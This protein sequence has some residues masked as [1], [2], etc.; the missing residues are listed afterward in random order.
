MLRPG[1]RLYAEEVLARFIEHPLWRCL[2]EH[3]RH[4]RFDRETFHAA[5]EVQGFHVVASRELFG[6]F[7][8][9]VAD[10]PDPGASELR[11]RTSNPS[12]G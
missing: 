7:A 1:G 11:S 2:L 10:K 8:W 12:R 9:F 6:Q 4:D 3:P 5:L